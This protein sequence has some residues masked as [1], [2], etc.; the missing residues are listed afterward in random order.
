MTFVIEKKGVGDT[1]AI[2]RERGIVFDVVPFADPEGAKRF[3][4]DWQGK[5]IYF[6][7]KY[8]A[9]NR[10]RDENGTP[11]FDLEWKINAIMIPDGFPETREAVFQVVCEALNIYGIA[12]DSDMVN[13]IKVE[14]YKNA[15]DAEIYG[16]HA[17]YWWHELG[18]DE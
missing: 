4:L 12:F 18:D 6:E 8:T 5:K 2:D 1:K 11:K 17:R 7:G 9:P 16:L 15:F 3:S 13:S 10:F 14:H